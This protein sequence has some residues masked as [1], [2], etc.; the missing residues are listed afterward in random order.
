MARSSSASPKLVAR[1][2][3]TGLTVEARNFNLVCDKAHDEVPY[4][5]KRLPHNQKTKYRHVCAACAYEKGYADGLAA[6]RD[7]ECVQREEDD[8]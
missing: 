8:A 1:V 6:A 3:D 4:D 2:G 7:P 5:V